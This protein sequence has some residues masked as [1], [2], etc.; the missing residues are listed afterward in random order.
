VCGR[1]TG[2]RGELRLAKLSLAVSDSF[3]P[4]R[5][6]G[7]R[8]KRDSRTRREEGRTRW[9]LRYPQ[10]CLPLG[11]LSVLGSSGPSRE[12]QIS[13]FS[14]SCTQPALDLI[15]YPVLLLAPDFSP[16]SLLISPLSPE[17]LPP[18]PAKRSW[19]RMRR[20]RIEDRPNED[21]SCIDCRDAWNGTSSACPAQPGRLAGWP[22][23]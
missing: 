16:P 9:A 20:T 18:V 6:N 12:P 17:L 3:L 10:S 13:S 1:A 15:A 14:S 5:G 19:K 2:R 7:S 8:R 23:R 4:K 11:S 21:N 22:T